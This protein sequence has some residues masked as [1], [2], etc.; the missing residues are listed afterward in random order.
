MSCESFAEQ[1]AG[2]RDIRLQDVVKKVAILDRRKFI[3]AVALVLGVVVDNEIEAGIAEKDKKKD[4]EAE[5]K[6]AR[7]KLLEAEQKLEKAQTQQ[8]QTELPK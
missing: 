7:E 3:V 1:N 5:L 6:E 8:M 4:V 2:V